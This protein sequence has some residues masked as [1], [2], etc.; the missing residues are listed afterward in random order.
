M[1]QMLLVIN[2]L[3]FISDNQKIYFS[4]IVP[5]IL[6]LLKKLLSNLPEKT[7]KTHHH[8]SEENNIS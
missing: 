2:F 8:V 3:V 4:P 7:H 1:Y 6:K 5:S